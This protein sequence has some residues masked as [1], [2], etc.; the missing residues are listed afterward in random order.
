MQF[1]DKG[2]L[3]AKELDKHILGSPRDCCRRNG[4]LWDVAALYPKDAKWGAQAPA[5][6]GGAVLDVAPEVR[7]QLDALV[8]T[9]E[10]LQ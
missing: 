5:Y 9:A 8:G 6:F 10:G 3:V 2:D 4:I 7:K 1:W